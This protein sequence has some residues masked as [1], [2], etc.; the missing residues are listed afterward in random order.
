VHHFEETP[1]ENKGVFR[2]TGDPGRNFFADYGYYM[3]T[4][5]SQI[6]FKMGDSPF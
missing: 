6:H 2:T 5:N 1:T 4:L 3:G